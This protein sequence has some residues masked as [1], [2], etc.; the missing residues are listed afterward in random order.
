MGALFYRNKRYSV[1]LI[2][3]VLAAGVSAILSVGRQEDPTISS[4]FATIVTPFPGADPARVESLITEKIENELR[5]IP[6]IRKLESTSRIGI[7]VVT[8][9]LSWDLDAV[10]IEQA[11]SEVR[12]AISDAARAFPPGVPEP[13]F[14]DDRTGAYS[15]ISAIYVADDVNPSPALVRRYAEILQDRLRGMPGTKQ[16]SMFGDREEQVLVTVDS[17]KLSSLGLRFADVA[18]AINAADSKVESG[19]LRGL[20]QDLQIEVS[21]EI[22]DLNRI[23]RI[24]LVSGSDGDVVRLSDIAKVTRGFKEPADG[25][26]FANGKRAVLVAAKTEEGVQVDRWNDQV[27]SIAAAFENELPGGIEHEL[28]FEQSRYTADRLQ[29][30]LVNMLIGAALV[31]GVLVVTLGWRSALIVAAILP[32]ATLASLA[33]F[34]FLGIPIH[35]MSVTGLIVALGLLV[36]AGIVMTD[37]IRR[38]LEKGESALVAVQESVARLAAP[39][40]ASTVTTALAFTPMALLP[41]PAGDFVGSIAAAVIIMLISS[42]G[43][44]MTITPA[45][46]GWMLRPQSNAAGRRRSGFE[47]VH[48]PSFARLFSKSL[49]IALRYPKTAIIVALVVPIM[50]FGAFPTLQAQFFPGVDRDQFYV[51]LQLPSGAAIAATERTVQRTDARL[52]QFEGVSSVHWVIGENAPAFYYNMMDNQDGVPGFAEALVTTMSP[53]ATERI[54]PDLQRALDADIPEARITVRGLVQGPPVNAPVEIRVVGPEIATLRSIGDDLRAI[55]AGVPEILQAKTQL[56]GGAPK[57]VLNLDENRAGILG[58]SLSE[59]ADQLSGRIDGAVGGSLVESSEELPVRVRIGDPERSSADR[60]ADTLIALPDSI[61]L[62]QQGQFTGV[63]LRSLGD[64][65]LVPS[66]SVIYRR[67]GERINTVQGYPHRTVLPEEALKTVLQRIDDAGF[68]LP[69]GYRLEVGGDADARNDVIASLLA[70][71]GLIFAL[72]VAAVVLTFNSYRLS[73]ITGG[74]SLL[75]VGLSLFSLAVF[76]YPFGIQALIGVIGSIGV[77]INAAIIIMT[78]LQRVPLAMQGDTDAIRDTVIAQ[79]R[80]IV[81]TAMTTFGGFLPLILAGGGFWPPFAMAIAGGVLLS[82]LVS[83]YFVPPMFKL[84]ARGHREQDAETTINDHP[85]ITDQ[86]GHIATPIP[87]DVPSG[88]P[89]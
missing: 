11:W 14:D 26:A 50:G 35:Q 85:R 66:D 25:M 10:E 65:E 28:L 37:E 67:N 51:Q 68:E 31:I 87:S 6:Q 12:D 71:A 84:V 8:A 83:F 57:T 22:E 73:A 32:L 16:V 2:L 78:A 27:R 77:S 81:S 49:D 3:M 21:G 38:K 79:S 72:T 56:T 15:S 45:L 1:L 62:T 33:G 29:F 17:A 23:E 5:E 70:G 74:V 41:G 59:V 4:I 76:Q 82:T 46:A 48:I 19:E 52:R 58:L 75:A 53:E 64:V 24:P 88:T 47:G 86:R 7:S 13:T 30:V 80:H 34:Q 89:A 36:D 39:L 61:L 18:R 54:L 42:F 69:P 55:M 43:L 63:P 40:L 60:L 9:E 20:G 44:A